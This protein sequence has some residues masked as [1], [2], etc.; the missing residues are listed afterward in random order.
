MAMRFGRLDLNLLVALDALLTERS[1]SLAADRLC[2]SQS[3]TSSALGRL[4]EYFGDELLVVKG[5]SMILTARAEEL[6][7]PVRA[8]LEQIRTTVSVAPPFDPAT[9]DRVVRIMASDYSTEVLLTGVLADLEKAAPNMR[10]EIQPMH[11]TPIEAIE[12]GY[13]D[14][15]LTI[16]YAISSDHPSQLLFEDDYVVVGDRNNPALAAP[17]TRDLYFSLGHVTARFGKARVP[18][19]EDWFVR[20][21]KQQRRVEVVAPSFLSLPGLVVGTN[22]IATMHRRMAE[23]VVRTQPLV[24]REIPFAIPPIR[25]SIQWN[26]ANTNDRALRWVVEKLATAAAA[27]KSGTDNVVP[28]DKADISRSEIEVEYRMNHPQR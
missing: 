26:I 16:D 11:D 28:L 20:R 15:L 25:E 5:R 24:M 2:L 13:I 21:Q 22:R 17:M 9:A 14:L 23:M 7:E 6:I 19:F 18:A 12:R 10:F 3:A 1:V 4:R 27:Y 8:V